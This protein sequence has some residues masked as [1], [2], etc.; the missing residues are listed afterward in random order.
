MSCEEKARL[1]GKYKVAALTFW[2]A[3]KDLQRTRSIS[4]GGVKRREQVSTEARLMH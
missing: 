3:E 2:A 1:V 4:Q